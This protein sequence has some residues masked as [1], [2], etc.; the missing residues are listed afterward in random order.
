MMFYTDGLMYWT[1]QNK[2]TPS[3][4]TYYYYKSSAEVEMT[5]YA[6]LA[7]LHEQNDKSSVVGDEIMGIV[8]WLS[9][10]RNSYGGFASTQVRIL[11]V[12]M[13]QS[14]I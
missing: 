5:T 13:K 10:Q 11:L 3:P 4:Y 9:K 1:E 6:L 8:R 2:A 12:S 7:I 14:K